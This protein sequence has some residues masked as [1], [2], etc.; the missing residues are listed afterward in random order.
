MEKAVIVRV[1]GVKIGGVV[2]AAAAVVVIV[3][4]VGGLRVGAQL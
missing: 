1:A 4:G 3:V 2:V